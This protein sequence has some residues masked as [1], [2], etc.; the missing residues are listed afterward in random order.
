MSG[1]FAVSSSSH[2]CSSLSFTPTPASTRET[3]QVDEGHPAADFKPEQVPSAA[4][5][6]RHRRLPGLV[7]LPPL[8]RDG[9]PQLRRVG[10]PMQQHV[11]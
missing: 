11:D 3:W 9:P 4:G 6:V 1:R 2:N 5:L 8:A 7:Q 10:V